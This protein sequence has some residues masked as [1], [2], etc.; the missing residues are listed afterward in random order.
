M[1]LQVA[2]AAN[3]ETTLSSVHGQQLSGTGVTFW[4]TAV[5]GAET[6]PD[7][8]WGNRTYSDECRS[9]PL[10]TVVLGFCAGL[11]AAQR[12]DSLEQVAAK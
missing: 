7:R 3:P 2:G 4:D 6:R 10:I 1:A 9:W 11:T 5:C 12:A 8:F